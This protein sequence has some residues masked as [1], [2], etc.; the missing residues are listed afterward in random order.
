MMKCDDEI[1]NILVKLKILYF[2]YSLK[3][4]DDFL[5]A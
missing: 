1:I 3:G 5:S 2:T 4:L